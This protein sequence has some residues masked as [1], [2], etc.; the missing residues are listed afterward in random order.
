MI[1]KYIKTTWIDNKTPVN[2]ANLNHIETAISDL[3][4]NAI[5]S[6]E[7]IEGDGIRIAST[8]CSSD[9]YGSS[10]KGLQISVSDRVMQSDS[11]VGIEIVTDQNSILSYEK[12]RLYIFLHPETKSLVKFVINGVTIFEA[13]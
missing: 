1:N 13:E 7:I 10:S 5:S 8:S 2:A 11:C 12:D 9:S 4:A 3:Y 6:S